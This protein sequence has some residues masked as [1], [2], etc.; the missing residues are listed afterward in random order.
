MQDNLVISPMLFRRLHAKMVGETLIEKDFI[1]DHWSRDP[2]LSS[3]NEGS[4]ALII[5]TRAVRPADIRQ[6]VSA[7]A[8]YSTFS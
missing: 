3:Q 4:F 8:S 2:S 7:N 6:G 1:Y 5:E